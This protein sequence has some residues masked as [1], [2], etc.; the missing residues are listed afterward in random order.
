MESFWGKLKCEW[1][2][3]EH[4]KTREETRAAVFEYVDVF[5]NRRRIHASNG[6]L[7]PEE[8]YNKAKCKENAAQKQN[9]EA[10]YENK[11]YPS[12]T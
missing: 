10:L 4:F 5:Y 2:Y 9:N 11:S 1:L 6:Y 8:F 7:T 12:S 3:G